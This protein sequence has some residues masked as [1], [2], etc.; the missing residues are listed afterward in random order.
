[1]ATN[2]VQL[3]LAFARGE[4]RQIANASEGLDLASLLPLLFAPTTAL[5]LLLGCSSE[6]KASDWARCPTVAYWIAHLRAGAT[7]SDDGLSSRPSSGHTTHLSQNDG[8]DTLLAFTAVLTTVG[9]FVAAKDNNDDVV[10]L[11]NTLMFVS[12][13]MSLVRACITRA[14]AIEWLKNPALDG[15]TS[16][17]PTTGGAGA[18]A[19]DDLVIVLGDEADGI[20]EVVSTPAVVYNGAPAAA[21]ARASSVRPPPVPRYAPF[22]R[23]GMKDSLPL[24]ITVPSRRP[25]GVRG[26]ASSFFSSGG[27]ASDSSRS[28]AVS[29]THTTGGP[30][31]T[32][33]SSAVFLPSYANGGTGGRNTILGEARGGSS[34]GRE[35]QSVEQMSRPIKR[36]CTPAR[37]SYNMT[38]L[39]E[40][41]LTSGDSVFITGGGGVGKTRLLREVAGVFRST[42]GGV[43]AGLGIIAPS[44]VAAAISGGVT[45]H[46]F[47]RLPMS[48]FDHRMTEGEDASRI[49]RRMSKQTKTRLATTDLLLLDEVSM[50]SSRMFTTLIHCMDSSRRDFKR[51]S[52][53]R[54]IAFGDFFQLPPVR[55]TEDDDII[56][57]RE[58]GYAFE[59]DLWQRVFKRHVLELSYVWRQE[60]AEFIEMLGQL[61][62]GVVSRKLSTFLD[63]RQRLYKQ[64]VN[65]RAGIGN[66]ITHIFPKTKDVEQHNA[67]CL[68]KLER[69]SRSKRCVYTSVDVAVDVDLSGMVLQRVLN[70]ALLAPRVL[71]LCVGARVA[72]CTSQFKEKGIFNGTVGVVTD[73]VDIIDDEQAFP[74]VKFITVSERA[75]SVVVQPEVMSLESVHHCGPYAQRRQVPLVLAWAVTVHRV[76][77]LSL[78]RAVLDLSACFAPGMVYVALSRVRSMS[79]VF[80][81]SFDSSKVAA[82]GVVKAFYNEQQSLAEDYSSCL[83]FPV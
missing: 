55:D 51:A 9:G 22:S 58:A 79:G 27:R 19:S 14:E 71:K 3:F 50:V 47:L 70:K 66:D 40:K 83:R 57:D 60:D 74:V 4:L 72:M 30:S 56:F 45:L 48:C 37:L 49:Y 52:P 77:G 25:S 20:C 17:I 73:F 80:V 38:M 7:Q 31:K 61:R 82:N 28:A 41:L 43:K 5:G 10:Q 54:M 64:V 21:R 42:R 2:G 33:A 26:A 11:L 39:A 44:G 29:G 75:V 67:H 12:Q 78:D 13:D 46:A 8:H 34:R 63:E 32:C 6:R 36:T 59:A 35:L 1:M 62:V 65:S 69:E 16:S 53:W 68:K 81:K 76:Q 15:W 18:A 23:Q 24:P